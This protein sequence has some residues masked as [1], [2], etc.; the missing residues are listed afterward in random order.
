MSNLRARTMDRPY[1]WSQEATDEIVSRYTERCAE[2]NVGRRN[3]ADEDI[4][5]IF[6]MNE[7]FFD[8]AHVY[9]HYRWT[10]G[11]PIPNL[12][13]LQER[14]FSRTMWSPA[15]GG[16]T[17][18]IEFE[19]LTG[20]TNFWMPSA[21]FL[22]VLP[23]RT[24]FPSVARLLGGLGYQTMGLH[25]NHSAFYKRNLVYPNLGFD[26]FYDLAVFDDPR[27]VGRTH[28]VSDAAAYD[29][30][31]EKL[32][33]DDEKKF[34]NLVTVQLHWPYADLFTEDELRFRLV[35]EVENTREIEGFLTGLYYADRALGEFIERL[36]ESERRV[37]MVFW[38][39]HSP[40]IWRSLIHTEHNDLV[41]KLPLVI[42]K[43]FDDVADLSHIP[44]MVTP[45]QIPNLL[46]EALGAQKP[47]LYCLLDSLLEVEPALARNLSREVLPSTTLRDYEF[48]NY[49]MLGRQRRR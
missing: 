8:P 4:D 11:N 37:I 20:L 39:D 38:G 6:V 44:E 3:L 31:L 12:H 40:G 26:A 48:I 7:S 24:G 16:S 47:F 23:R 10:G 18:N 14:T 1:G 21:P 13:A 27:S 49:Q 34:I 45:N 9:E 22:D 33:R 30:A 25:P 42:W 41:H 15:Y 32:Y 17:A 36:E 2:L 5:I 28:L 43:N 35:D 46:F 29:K 19:A